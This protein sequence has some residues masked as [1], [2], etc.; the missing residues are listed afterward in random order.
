MKKINEENLRHISNEE[1][2]EILNKK[3]GIIAYGSGSGS[4]SGSGDGSGCGCGCGEGSGSGCGCGEGSGSGSGSGSG[5]GSGDDNDYGSGSME[6]GSTSANNSNFSWNITGGFSYEIEVTYDE[7]GDKIYNTRGTVTAACE[8]CQSYIDGM[9]Y[10]SSSS[11]GT[12]VPVNDFSNSVSQTVSIQI[13]A[14]TE[15]NGKV[16]DRYTGDI[17]VSVSLTFDRKGTT[18][19][20]SIGL[21]SLISCNIS[22]Y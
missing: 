1:V 21:V 5:D 3:T 19:T 18:L 8:G 10:V 6:A 2:E 14:H 13:S 7:N 16:I 20:K 11:K 4:G 12:D 17:T 9:F 15:R 22:K